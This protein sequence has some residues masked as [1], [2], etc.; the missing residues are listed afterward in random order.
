MCQYTFNPPERPQHDRPQVEVKIME[1][2]YLVEY[3]D[4]VAVPALGSMRIKLTAP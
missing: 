4:Y 2:A 3:W 1:S